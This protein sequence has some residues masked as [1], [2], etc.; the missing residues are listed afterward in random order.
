M[1]LFLGTIQALLK[2]IFVSVVVHVVLLLLHWISAI[3]ELASMYLCMHSVCVICV[4][5]L[6]REQ[7]TNFARQMQKV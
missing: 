4:G 7:V 6:K 3:Y 1:Y 5:A 2:D